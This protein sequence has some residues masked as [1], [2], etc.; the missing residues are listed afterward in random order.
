MR[1]FT[2]AQI[3]IK[4]GIDVIF[5]YRY[6]H[7][8]LSGFLRDNNFKVFL[9]PEPEH[10]YKLLDNDVPYAKWLGVDWK[11]DSKETFDVLQSEVKIDCIVVDHY[12]ID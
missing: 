6:F 7:G 4:K 11:C 1:C 5:I 9:L 12:G 10:N 3:L 2:L 8:N